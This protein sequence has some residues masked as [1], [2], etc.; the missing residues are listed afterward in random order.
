MNIR[1]HLLQNNKY[2]RISDTGEQ[3]YVQHSSSNHDSLISYIS[4]K[5]PTPSELRKIYFDTLEYSKLLKKKY[6]LYPSK[7]LTISEI[8]IPDLIKKHF[9]STTI[10]V[11]N[12]DIIKTIIE[13]NKATK[14]KILVLNLASNFKYGGG[15]ETGVMAQEEELFRKT[16]YGLHSGKELYPLSHYQFVVTEN[17][18][19]VKD[20]F[21]NKIDM[22]DI[23]D[24]DMIAMAG[25]Y[26]PE[27]INGNFSKKDYDLTYLKIENIFK[28]AIF[29]SY[30][31]LI[32]SAFGCGGFGNPP[33][34]IIEIYNKCLEKYNGYFENVIFSVKSVQDN[35]FEL[36][37]RNIKRKF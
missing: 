4:N 24:V 31:N 7:K 19:I 26:R 16:D 6:E 10:L 3:R 37:D 25:L 11:V 20:E 36:F 14:S 17:V 5:C 32:L 21:Y 22:V 8:E 13:F 29:K 35:N 28:Y 33:L 15:V 18:S 9:S 12:A 27:L 30:T 23:F 1:S 2:Q 34:N